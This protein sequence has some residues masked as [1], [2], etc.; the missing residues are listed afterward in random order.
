M[1]LVFLIGMPGAGKS[2]WGRLLSRHLHVPYIDLD[3]YIVYSERSSI[4]S[5]FSDYG[6]E[7]F[8]IKER[9]HLS[10]LVAEAKP[11][12]IIACGGGTPCYHNNMELMNNA[13]TTIYL[14]A[15]TEHLLC[16]MRNTIDMRPLLQD[17]DD[18]PALLAN[19]LVK[20]RAYY[21]M[22]H[23]ILQTENISLATFEQIITA[24]I[25]RQ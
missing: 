21:E 16:N 24:C 11:G 8:R 15:Q 5:L 18:V 1:S 4:T 14:E 13:G 7:W 25:N 3:R 6:E 17:K 23:Y 12:T 10:R 2:H 22:A 19:M 9:E 20:R